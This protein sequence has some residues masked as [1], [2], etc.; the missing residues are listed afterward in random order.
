[1]AKP[2]TYEGYWQ[3]V[4]GRGSAAQVVAD[5]GLDP[6]DRVGLSEWLGQCESD[7]LSMGLT[8]RAEREAA[9]EEW[10]ARGFHAKAL[11]DLLAVEV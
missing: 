7:S 10:E 5:Y 3:A 4:L 1:M 6:R 8:D 2:W 11:A 9:S